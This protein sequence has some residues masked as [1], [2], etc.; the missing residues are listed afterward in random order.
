MHKG[1]YVECLYRDDLAPV[2]VGITSRFL[3]NRN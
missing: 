2:Y 3:P 1:V